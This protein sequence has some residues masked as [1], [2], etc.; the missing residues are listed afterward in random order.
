MRNDLKGWSSWDRFITLM[1]G[2]LRGRGLA[3]EKDQHLPE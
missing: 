1:V 3:G 2:L